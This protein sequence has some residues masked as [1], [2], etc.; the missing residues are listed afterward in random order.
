[1]ELR[2]LAFDEARRENLPLITKV[3]LAEIEARMQAD[4]FQRPPVPFY[5][6]RHGRANREEIA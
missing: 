1:M 3:V 4:R 5:F 2:W 6:Y